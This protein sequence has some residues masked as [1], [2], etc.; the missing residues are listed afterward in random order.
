M[1]EFQA[2]E[3]IQVDV[4]NVTPTWLALHLTKGIPDAFMGVPTAMVGV[5]T[6]A[7]TV[8]IME[9]MEVVEILGVVCTIVPGAPILPAVGVVV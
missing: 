3:G 4:T 8:E 2:T 1:S 9:T 6:L 5:E 7:T